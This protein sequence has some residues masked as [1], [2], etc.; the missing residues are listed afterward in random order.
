MIAQ[1]QD[2]LEELHYT[3]KNRDIFSSRKQIKRRR[4]KFLCRNNI[5][6]L[7]INLSS[8]GNYRESAE[9]MSKTLIAMVQSYNPIIKIEDR[10][11]LGAILE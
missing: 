5:L 2:I 11:H 6:I 8:T 3:K 10:D 4:I 1:T 7:R 9:E